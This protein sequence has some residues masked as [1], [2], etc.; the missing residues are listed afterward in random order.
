M[1]SAHH[2]PNFEFKTTTDKSEEESIKAA[3]KALELLGNFH[4]VYEVREVI[5]VQED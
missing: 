5:K 2:Y 3:F 4:R 1:S